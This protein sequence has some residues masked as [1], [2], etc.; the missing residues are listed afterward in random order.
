MHTKGTVSTLLSCEQARRA[1][2]RQAHLRLSALDGLR[3]ETD[4]KF[5]S[6]DGDER[7][8]IVL[9]APL[10]QQEPPKSPLITEL[11][12]R[13]QGIRR[14]KIVILFNDK[15]RLLC[16]FMHKTGIIHCTASSQSTL[17]LRRWRS[18]FSSCASRVDWD[19]RGTVLPFDLGTV[20]YIGERKHG[21]SSS[22]ERPKLQ[23]L[24]F[25]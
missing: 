23:E 5:T 11:G 2:A 25:G 10:R 9:G 18:P 15:S 21:S 4:D 22:T 7:Y 8:I 19:R 6:R 12:R 17:G 1:L 13:L 16:V 24:I 3:C 20:R 14:S